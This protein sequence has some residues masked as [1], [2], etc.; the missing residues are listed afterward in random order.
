LAR[1]LSQ[2][3]WKTIVHVSHPDRAR[4]R[5]NPAIPVLFS[6]SRGTRNFLA[7]WHGACYIVPRILDRQ[8][9]I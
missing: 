2:F 7:A 4:I 8:V 9:M 5:A 3:G 1:I 6:E